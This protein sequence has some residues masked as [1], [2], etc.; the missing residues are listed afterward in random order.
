MASDRRR[1]LI[2][3]DAIL[4]SARR[5]A[6]VHH[7]HRTDEKGSRKGKSSATLDSPPIEKPPDLEALRKARLDYINTAADEP[8]KKMKYIGETITREPARKVDVDHVRKASGSKR[9]RK[10]DDPLHRHRQRKVRASEVATG[11]YQSVYERRSPEQDVESKTSEPEEQEVVKLDRQEGPEVT[12]SDS[13]LPTV[14]RRSKRGDEGK[15]VEREDSGI[16]KQRRTTRRRQTVP[17]DR[18][19]HVRRNSYGID[20]C[21]AVLSH[22]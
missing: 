17:T 18:V 19:R 16:D 1:D 15:E 5:R 12:P 13:I 10:S 20:E 22:R 6:T 7:R 11:G 21:E 14:R 2:Q 9:R 8:K 4:P 3:V